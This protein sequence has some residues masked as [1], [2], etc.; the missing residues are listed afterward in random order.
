MSRFLKGRSWIVAPVTGIYSNRRLNEPSLFWKAV[1]IV[2]QRVFV[3][4]WWLKFTAPTMAT[5]SWSFNTMFSAFSF[6]VL[7]PVLAARKARFFH[8]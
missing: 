6:M 4:P 7:S 3:S 1:P 2:V 8:T 5:H